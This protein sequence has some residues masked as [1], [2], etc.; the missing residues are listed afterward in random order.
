MAARRWRMEKPREMGILTKLSRLGRGGSMT[1]LRIHRITLL[2]ACIG[3]V[4]A[5]G[6]RAQAAFS[7]IDLGVHY[8]YNA[9]FDL[10]VAGAQ[11]GIPIGRRFEVVPSLDRYWNVDG[12]Q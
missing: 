7:H 8:G 12:S 9:G 3:M 1:C 2:A 6:P 4:P 5:P 10:N 11:A